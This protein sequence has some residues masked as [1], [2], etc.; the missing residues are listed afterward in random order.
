M[1]PPPYSMPIL[2]EPTR[3]LGWR[4]SR[5]AE[6]LARRRCRA[7]A[8]FCSPVIRQSAPKSVDSHGLRWTRRRVLRVRADPHQE[9]VCAVRAEGEGF[10][11]SSDPK[12]RNG[13]RD[14]TR[15]LKEMPVCSQI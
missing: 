5:I 10:E 13:F 2:S 1:K 3:G 7:S 14:E 6:T 12:A 15:F 9:R 4:R 8:E 11:P